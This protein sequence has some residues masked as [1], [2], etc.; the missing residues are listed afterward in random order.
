MC[1]LLV[2]LDRG[3][4][5][6]VGKLLLDA[7]LEGDALGDARDYDEDLCGGHYCR[8]ADRERLLRDLGEIVVEEPRVCDD[9][10]VGEAYKHKRTFSSRRAL[11]KGF[12]DAVERADDARP[13][14][15]GGAGLVE[16]DVAI[17]PDAREEEV[18]PAELGDRRLVRRA[19]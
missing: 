11:E 5:P 18:D 1:P 3:R 2:E 4:G 17:G 19:L 14:L 15:E 16:G 6:D 9:R 7:V 10:V 8:D 13:R 12:S